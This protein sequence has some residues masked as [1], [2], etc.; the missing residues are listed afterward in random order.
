M[1]TQRLYFDNQ[2]QL[3]FPFIPFS[4]LGL[5]HSCILSQTLSRLARMQQLFV[6]GYVIEAEPS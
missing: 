5:S 6:F 2:R 4:C 3:F 1:K